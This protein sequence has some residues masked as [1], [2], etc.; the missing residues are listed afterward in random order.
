MNEPK[1][2]HNRPVSDEL[3]P[4]IYRALIGTAAWFAIAIWGF[5][6]GGYVD[7]LLAVVCGFALVA[8][9]IPTI[10]S[11]VGHDRRHRNRQRLRDWSAGDFAT[12]TDHGRAANAAVEVLLPLGA[13]A[14]GM[15][16][17]AIVFV[18]ERV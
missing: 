12:W 16:A 5:S 15:T 4:V 10:L 13:I 9:A 1:L 17:I 7:W 14:V 3:H 8:V 2:R 18:V 6:G 11:R